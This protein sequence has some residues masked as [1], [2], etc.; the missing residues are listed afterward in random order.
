MNEQLRQVGHSAAFSA[1][2]MLLVGFWIVFEGD[3][4]KP[5]YDVAVA[6]ST[7]SMRL[8]GFGL[9]VTAVVCYAGRRVGLLLDAIIGIGAGALIVVSSITCMVLVAG[10]SIHRIVFC[11]IGLSAAGAARNSW[12]LFRT[13]A[14]GFDSDGGSSWFGGATKRKLTPPPPAPEPLHPASIRPASLSSESPPPGGYL[15]ALARED[16]RPDRADHE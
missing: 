14:N 5:A 15:A 9:G 13:G 3:K 6:A 8:G 16:E 4:S 12:A 10:F 2:I 1:L 7:W 11:L